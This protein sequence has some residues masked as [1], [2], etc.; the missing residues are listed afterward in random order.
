MR[1][2]AENY[3]L[4]HPNALSGICT[5]E[6]DGVCTERANFQTN[7]AVFGKTPMKSRHEQNLIRFTKY[8]YE[9]TTEIAN[10]LFLYDVDQFNDGTEQ[11]ALDLQNFLELETTTVP[12]RPVGVFPQWLM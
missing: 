9:S 11:F 6:K 8:T 1:H 4:P 7:L 3:T 5:P 10:P 2:A 12:T